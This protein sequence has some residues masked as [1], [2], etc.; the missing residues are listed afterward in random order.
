MGEPRSIYW[1]SADGGRLHALDWGGPDGLAPVVG[2]PGL[3]RTARD[4]A[5]LA[6]WLDG[7]RRVIG[8]DLRGRGTSDSDPDPMRYA[9]DTYI[10]DIDRLIEALGVEQVILFGG[11]NG[12]V[13]SALYAAQRPGRVAGLLFND[14]AHRFEEAGFTRIREQMD[15]GA[16]W[17][18]WDEAARNLASR[19]ATIHPDYSDGEWQAMAR[20]TMR[21]EP[22][23]SIVADFDP[24]IMIP[25]EKP[26]SMASFD[27]L[28]VYQASA[29][30]PGLLLR[31]SLSDLL[32]ESTARELDDALPLLEFATVAN[33][34]HLP[35]LAEPES[36]AA[37]E[38]L[39]ARIED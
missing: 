34:G 35:D 15:L 31:G 3:N 13:L 26:G 4:F 23:G 6:E 1:H 12:G 29:G 37:I 30:V 27:L 16:H 2:L 22:D 8:V 20:R 18:S 32:S 10:E 25:F 33:V 38:R 28:P 5:P 36:V 7:R 14:V 21:E 9:M 39:L 17:A 19:Y 11:S 24:G